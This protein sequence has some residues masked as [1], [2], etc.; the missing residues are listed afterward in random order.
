MTDLTTDLLVL[1]GRSAPTKKTT[2]LTTTRSSTDS[3]GEDLVC[4][5]I[6]GGVS[7]VP[8]QEVAPVAAA[9]SEAT[10]LIPPPQLVDETTE[11]EEPLERKRR[12]LIT[13]KGITTEDERVSVPRQ[14]SRLVFMADAIRSGRSAPQMRATADASPARVREGG[15]TVAVGGKAEAACAKE[16]S[17]F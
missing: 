9:T 16:V 6:H 15:S 3:D 4:D 11:G 1:T 2:I 5:S 10:P 17:N 8:P 13:V 7:V 12:R 14:V